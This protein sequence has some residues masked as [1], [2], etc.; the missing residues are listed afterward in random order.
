MLKSLTMVSR[1]FD[2]GERIQPR[3]LRIGIDIDGIISGTEVWIRRLIRRGLKL[4]NLRDED[5]TNYWLDQLPQVQ[6]R[7]N[8][9]AFIWQLHSKPFIYQAS[10]PKPGAIETVNRWRAQGHEIWFITGRPLEVV[11]PTLL[12][13]EQYNL[14]WA[15]EKIFFSTTPD[16]TERPSFKKSIA[17]RLNLHVFIEDHAET[18]RGVSSRA[19][20]AKLVLECPWN[21]N[22]DIGEQAQFVKNW[23][24]IDA[25][26][27][28][29]S[30][31]PKL[32]K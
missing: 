29:L 26:V 16:A 1:E 27:Q 19:M 32:P 4:G 22:E 14:G 21:I 24:Q 30:R 17:Q 5:F 28:E 25:I 8:G 3:T 23:D 13:F 6:S 9:R 7:P 18:V 11:G 10:A 2:T 15:K 20:V 31:R 12:W